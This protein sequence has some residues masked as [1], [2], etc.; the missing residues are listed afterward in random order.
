M[1]RPRVM[2]FIDGQNLFKGLRRRFDTRL[3]PLLL[4]R[5]LAGPDRDLVGTH[6]YS[7]IHDPDEN[8]RM[9]RLVRRRHD[10]MRRTGVSVTERTLRYHWE[11][12]VPRGELDPPWYDS[13]PTRADARVEK[14]RGA[15]EKGIDVALAL[16]AVGSILTDECD[17]VVVVSRDRDLME[18]AA[19]V[20]QRCA[21][22]PVS[23]EVAYVSERRG[24]ERALSGYDRYIEIDE[25][26]VDRAADRFDYGRDLDEADVAAFLDSL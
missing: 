18:I 1:S 4:A 6:Y 8:E 10:L 12:R 5:E 17:V 23:V 16:D 19:E 15:R 3:H 22:K 14:Y 2:V 24:D 25:E 26:I 9:H 7:G 21:G 13:A 20:D 11:W